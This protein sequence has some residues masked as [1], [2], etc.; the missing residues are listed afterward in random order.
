MQ[1]IVVFDFVLM[2]RRGDQIIEMSSGW[3]S[4]DLHLLRKSNQFDLP[5]LGGTPQRITTIDTEDVRTSRKGWRFVV[6]KLSK[7]IQS[8]L[9]IEA[10]SMDKLPLDVKVRIINMRII[11]YRRTL[12]TCLQQ[13]CCPE[14]PL[15]STRLIETILEEYILRLAIV[16]KQ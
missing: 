7:P 8:V 3:T 10:R 15:I 4:V 2:V 9:K 1:L 16:S 14:M 6:K 13:Y 12:N 11:L 5:L